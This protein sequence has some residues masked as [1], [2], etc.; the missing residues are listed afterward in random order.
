LNIEC[1]LAVT[2]RLILVL[3]TLTANSVRAESFT[4]RTLNNLVRELAS[5]DFSASPKEDYLSEP[6][7]TI[8]FERKKD[9][10]IYIS[11]NIVLNKSDR[12]WITLADDFSEKPVLGVDNEAKAD[13]APET[14]RFVKAGSYKIRVWTKGRPKLNNIIVRSIPE[15]IFYK[16]EFLQKKPYF[17]DFLRMYYWDYLRENILDSYNVIVSDADDRYAPYINEWRKGG[18]KW[19]VGTG[20]SWGPAVDNVYK[21]WG[22]LMENLL[23]DGIIIDEFGGSD[24][25][26]AA[27]P[28]WGKTMKK[29]RSS[30]K[31]KGKMLYGFTG[32]SYNSRR[33]LLFD[34]LFE[35]GY[36][37]VPEAY[38]DEKPTE[39]GAE[40]HLEKYLMNVFTKWREGYPGVEENMVICLAPSNIPPRCSWNT[41]PNVNFKVFVDKQFYYLANHPAFKNLYGVTF[42]A[43]HYMD[44]EILRW[45]AKL[46]RHYM[47]EGN[48]QMLSTDPYILTHLIN[49]GFEEGQKGW[50]FSAASSGSIKVIDAAEMQF[51]KSRG[52]NAIPEGDK[53]LYTK[54][55]K[56]RPNIVSQKIKN[57]T[58]GR[59]YSLK[60]YNTD[61]RNFIE[62]KRVAVSIQL[63][64][65]DLLPDKCRDD[66]FT[67]DFPLTKKKGEIK[68][69][70]NGHYRVFRA[71]TD[72]GEL[73]LSDWIIN[74]MAGGPPGQEI[75][76]DFIELQPYFSDQNAQ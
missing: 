16:V 55:A 63:K 22:K 31:C 70:W 56:N 6:Y 52:W 68:V 1:S 24:K 72:S 53:V 17:Q 69:C 45:F 28:L 12:V 11:I 5:F 7:K 57:L 42:F 19:L 47:I 73:I 25:F 4:S 21:K 76:W 32:T 26:V 64:G 49:P 54:R 44:E 23:Y 2:Y 34:T 61:F 8:P 71:K 58:P 51:K 30:P 75:I 60:V 39:K 35:S 10:W 46:I 9:G 59:L 40:K 13:K 50:D 15:I 38:Y 48:R 43:A 27:Y 65:V 18:G 36:K 62:K 66:V 33:R 41:C 29:I 37:C 3:L 67:Y 14:M 74:D 20:I